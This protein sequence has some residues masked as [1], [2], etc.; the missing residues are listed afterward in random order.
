MYESSSPPCH[1][2][3]VADW[4]SR[5]DVSAWPIERIETAGSTE[6]RWLLEPQTGAQWLHKSTV[7]P[8]NLIE[9]GEDWT[10]VVSTQVAMALNVPCA[11]TRLC[12][13]EGRRGS[14]S[15]SVRPADY[16]LFEGRVVLERANAP[17]YVAHVEG[18]PGVDPARPKVRR[19]GHSLENVKMALR[20][21]AQPPKFDGPF[22]CDA[23]DVFAG[24]LL[25]D[26]VIANR[27]RHEQNWAILSPS[28]TTEDEILSPS[29][30]HASSLGFNLTDERR[31]GMLSEPTMLQRWAEKGTAYRFEHVGTPPTL[32][33]HAVSALRLCSPTGRTWWKDRVS[34]LDLRPITTILQDGLTTV[35]H[36]S[37]TFATEILDLNLRRLRDALANA[38]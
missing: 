37:S 28:L 16:N 36:P 7:I 3:L 19:P 20:G 21:I 8:S 1:A 27:D 17:G 38:S 14:I 29:Y 5:L 31:T 15:R 32:I 18:Q 11:D 9:Q 33:E 26:A 2:E 34:A 25:L 30:D 13:R 12:L 24:Y 4:W 10:E 23:F 35:S 22:G 6:N